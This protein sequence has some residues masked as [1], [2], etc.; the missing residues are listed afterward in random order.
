MR[1]RTFAT[2]GALVL[3]AAFVLGVAPPARAQ[4]GAPSAD[5]IAALRRLGTSAGTPVAGPIDAATY[6]L[7]PGDVVRVV[8][9]GP[10]LQ[11][12][13]VDVGPEGTVVI[14]DHGAIHLGGLTLDQARAEVRRRIGAVMR[15]DVR[16][17]LELARVRQLRVFLAGDVKMNGPIELPAT[18][19]VSDALA[20]G[21]LVEVSGSRRNLELRHRDGTKELA[22]LERMTRLADR[23]GD[24]VVR[25]DDVIYVPPARE[26]IFADGAVAHGGRFERAPDD[27]LHR[28]LALAGGV[29]STARREH[30]L[31]LRWTSPTT[32][33]STWVDLGDVESGHFDPALRD[34]DR[35]M[36]YFLA[37][38]HRYE[39][40]SIF[41][42]VTSPGHYPL[43]SGVTRLSDLVRA[44]GGFLPRADLS[45]IHVYRPRPDAGETDTEV[46]RLSRLSRNEMTS[47]E[48]EVL[49][50]RLA[51]RRPD[52]RVDWNR[53]AKV[54][55]TDIVLQEGDVVRVD[56]V[57]A[58]VR[59]D[60]QVRRPGLVR[61]EPGASLERYVDDAGGFSR[62]A[63]RGQTLVTRAVTG[64]TLPARE[65]ESIE[66]G[67]LI[68]V[69]ERPD[70][71][72]WQNFGTLITV[73]A[74][75]ATLI[76]AVRR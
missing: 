54:P 59:V 70:R 34:G 9:S 64:Q 19:R 3:V 44:A 62:H 65:V 41:G 73:A 1:P 39:G 50:T 7:G 24:P 37:D 40:A 46:E 26:W 66:P 52:F 23:G 67:D 63:A 51:Q 5:S 61:Y 75:V 2:G 42:E 28:L 43:T 48:Y 47:S 10:L 27:S 21:T 18:A 17:D 31:F 35:L 72:I 13:T 8:F 76:I 69:P 25:D 29:V 33:E 74:Q 14:P 6:V 49:R 12:V 16:I 4:F 36:V 32:R 22:D 15:R 55:A 53:I 11:E 57:A 20:G 45:G 30:A 56:P 58:S 38:Y 71:T 60:G 68:W